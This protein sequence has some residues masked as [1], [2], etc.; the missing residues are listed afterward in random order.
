M[1]INVVKFES[2]EDGNLM[3]LGELVFEEN[4]KQAGISVVDNNIP[5]PI[6]EISG[7]GSLKFEGI[8]H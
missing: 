8:A 7:L 2:K 4:G 3:A 5:E 6:A 1:K